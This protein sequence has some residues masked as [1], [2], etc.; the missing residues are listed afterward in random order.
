MYSKISTSVAL[1]AVGSLAVACGSGSADGD[2]PDETLTVSTETQ[3][4]PMGFIEGDELKGFNID[5]GEALA[6]EMDV[7]IDWSES[8]F[9]QFISDVS[10][11]RSDAVIA[12]MLDNE[13]R[14][15][16][17]T[18][19]DFLETGFQFFTTDD[20][21]AEQ[22]IEEIADLCGLTVAASRNSSYAD[23][24]GEWSDENC[25]GDEISVLDADG[26]PDAQLQLRQGRAEAV[27][28]TNETIAYLAADDDSVMTVGDPITSSYYGMFVDKDNDELANRFADA[29]EVLIEDGT[30]Q[31]IASEWGLENQA[32][33]E[34]T[35]NLESR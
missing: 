11:S 2:A 10:S 14:Q 32:V 12:G 17:V 6:E 33:D 30:Y 18:F 13:E 25:D 26:S 34:V 21:A 16:S 15:E 4:P 7:N 1:L 29:L 23:A 22:G 19:V 24:I 5:I 9:S 27:M 28:Q 31:D 35:V 8:E 20:V 3:F